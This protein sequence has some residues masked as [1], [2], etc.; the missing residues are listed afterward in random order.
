MWGVVAGVGGSLL[1]GYLANK[2]NRKMQ[3]HQMNFQSHQSSTAYQRSMADMR[4]AGL[5]PMLAY[6]QGGAS[7]PTGGSGHPQQ[8]IGESIGEG[9]STALETKRLNADIKAINSKVSLNK[10]LNNQAKQQAK[11]HSAS[12]KQVGI[13][14]KIS[15]YDIQRAKNT[16]DI[17]KDMGKYGKYAQYIK[18]LW[19]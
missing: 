4:K 12:A 18:N 6:Q 13:N 8:N 10:S 9:V 1:G 5:N 3:Q 19:K 17:E 11:L 7:T 14:S 16:S 2:N 15:S